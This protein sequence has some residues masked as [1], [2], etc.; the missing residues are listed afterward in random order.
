M[1]ED[2]GAAIRRVDGYLA[3]LASARALATALEIGLIEGLADGRASGRGELAA[4]HGLDAA[5]AALL[6][7]LLL[8]GAVL[9]EGRDG[10]AL[11]PGFADAWVDRDLLEARLEMALFAAPDV[12]V[13][14]TDLVRAPERFVEQA[15]TFR[16]FDYGRCLEAGPAAVT[17]ARRWVSYTT[18]L[19][20][21][22]APAC[23]ARVPLSE[24]RAVLD[25]GGNSGEF[26]VQMCRMSPSLRATVFDLPAVCA[27]GR[28]HVGVQPESDRIAF[29]AG[30]ALEDPLPG[31]HDLVTFK[32]V[33][34]DW[35][36]DPASRMLARAAS[37]VVPGG[38]ILIFERGPLELRERPLP[39][40]MLPLLV[41]SRYYRGPSLYVDVL[42]G[43]G[44]EVAVQWVRLDSPFLLLTA[45]QGG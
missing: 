3:D 9:E 20:R 38:R 33:L 40:S 31:G 32:S 12:A 42:R 28:D 21:Y 41:F 36:E 13:G 22:E 14:F 39:F 5:G 16:L 18:A 23:I 45:R 24:H 35:P 19:T 1:A 26:A 2:P 10:V 34:H 37:A 25:I 43:L 44:F 6:V 30:D 27:I 29:V 7:D 8:A 4:R 17:Q 15:R 11:S